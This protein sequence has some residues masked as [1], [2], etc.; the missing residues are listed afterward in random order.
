[1]ASEQRRGL[2]ACVTSRR[3]LDQVPVSHRSRSAEE[4]LHPRVASAMAWR[5]G[6]GLDV[7]E[8]AVGLAVPLQLDA[9]GF[10]HALAGPK[11]VSDLLRARPQSGAAV[12]CFSSAEEVEDRRDRPGVKD[13]VGHRG[14]DGPSQP[15][16][17]DAAST[18][19]VLGRQG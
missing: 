1:M 3:G 5:P 15:L 14:E 13:E 2:V 10:R 11:S 12:V 4:G 18:G 6:I 17:A 7:S 16:A 19:S 8:P 9:E